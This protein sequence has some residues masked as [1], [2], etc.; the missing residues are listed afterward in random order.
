MINS[1]IKA[2]RILEAFSPEKPRRSLGELA[3]A[4][5]YPKTTVYTLAA[6]LVHTGLLERVGEAYAVGNAV[7][8]LSQSSRVYVELRDRAAPILRELADETDQ[9]VYLT[10]PDGSMVLYVYAIESSHRLEAR[11]A[12]GDHAY[13]HSTSVGKAMLAFM[14]HDQRSRILAERGLPARTPNTVTDVNAIELE[15]DQIRRQGF[16][17]DHSENEDNTFCLGAPI[18]DHEGRVIAACS[19]SGDSETLITDGLRVASARVRAAADQISRRM[20]Y[21]PQRPRTWEPAG[22]DA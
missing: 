1:L 22:R 13:F 2:V 20:G 18:F 9:S 10:V 14:D 8:R 11:S 16:S 6:T 19:I 7:V 5:G 21:V 3:E 15:L 4:T 12:I 17:V